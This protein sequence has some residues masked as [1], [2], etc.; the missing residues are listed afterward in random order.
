MQT[1]S[2]TNNILQ[3]LASYLFNFSL[4]TGLATLTF[5]LISCGGGGATTST[6][7]PTPTITNIVPVGIVAS[8][9][10]RTMSIA[11]TNFASGMTLSITSSSGTTNII[12]TSV[13]ST[14]IV[15]S[16]TISSVPT[17][18]YVTVSIKSSGGTTLASTVLGVASANKT[19]ANGIQTIF[20]TKCAGCHTGSTAGGLD[21]SDATSGNPNTGVI[22][23]SSLNC[24]SRLRVTPGDPRRASSVL[25]DKIKAQSTGIAA[26]SGTPMP[27][28]GSTGLTA[29]EITDIVDWVAGGAN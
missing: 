16:V 26:C 20:S 3:K 5:G 12:P 28:S 9:V 13:T 22:G 25:I 10:P 8:S 23:M 7:I 1:E 2:C 17:D 24:S 15:A 6:D 27:P 4:M 14:V 18:N 19:V 11:G 21:L 29:Q